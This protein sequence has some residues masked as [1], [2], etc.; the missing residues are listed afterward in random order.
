MLPCNE[1]QLIAFPR[2]WQSRNSPARTLLL[3]ELWSW[4]NWELPYWILWTVG[5]LQSTSYQ[6]TNSDDLKICFGR[7]NWFYSFWHS[8]YI[9]HGQSRSPR[10]C[11]SIESWYCLGLILWYTLRSTCHNCV[12]CKNLITTILRVDLWLRYI[13]F[14]SAILGLRLRVSQNFTC[15]PWS[16]ST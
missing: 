8:R 3:Y 4:A 11:S 15:I 9:V 5:L 6:F 10:L 16:Y 12:Q 1:S 14:G 13:E 7:Y 2:H